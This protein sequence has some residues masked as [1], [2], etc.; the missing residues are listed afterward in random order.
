[1]DLVSSLVQVLRPYLAEGVP[2]LHDAADLAGTSKRS[3]QRVLAEEGFSY[4]GILQ[5]VKF[6]AARELL[7]Q[8]EIKIT[9]VA[10][11][12][13]FRDPAHFPRFFRRRAGVTP[14]EYR[15]TPS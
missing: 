12:T 13:G 6:D 15:D 1:L 8:P 9:E 3:L 10:H 4:R 5:R 7:K 2:D 11:D 14:R